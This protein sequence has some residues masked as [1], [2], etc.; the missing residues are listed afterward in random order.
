MFAAN[1]NGVFCSMFSI[2]IVIEAEWKEMS[3][4]I[5]LKKTPSQCKQKATQMGT[6]WW[7]VAF[8]GNA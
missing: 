2:I 4:K 3:R 8:C 5:L 7:W 1:S 6:N